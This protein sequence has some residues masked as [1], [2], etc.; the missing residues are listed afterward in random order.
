MK[1]IDKL[2][3]RTGADTGFRVRRGANLIQAL[4]KV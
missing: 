3:V 4:G 1:D 2:N